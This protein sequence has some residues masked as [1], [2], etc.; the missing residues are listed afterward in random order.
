MYN[1]YGIK[2]NLVL[3]NF[4][5]YLKKSL[6]MALT[7]SFYDALKDNDD[8][9]LFV[10]ERAL[11][12]VE[13]R[14]LGVDLVADGQRRHQEELV[15][16]RAETHVQLTLVQGKELSLWRLPRLEIPTNQ[17]Q[18]HHSQNNILHSGIGLVNLRHN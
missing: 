10:H 1:I 8:L 9:K 3:K 11:R 4:H 13:E 12:Q 7:S 5:F 16:P 15:R 17:P 14:A 18:M 2:M 6:K